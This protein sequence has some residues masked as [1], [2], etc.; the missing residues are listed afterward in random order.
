[1]ALSAPLKSVP[2]KRTIFAHNLVH[3]AFKPIGQ[4]PLKTENITVTAF[5]SFQYDK[6]LPYCDVVLE[7]LKQCN[8]TSDTIESL[9][10]FVTESK[11]TL[12]EDQQDLD[13]FLLDNEDYSQHRND[14]IAKIKFIEESHSYGMKPENIV[15][16][17]IKAPQNDND[18]EDVKAYVRD[19]LQQN[20]RTL[21]I[22]ELLKSKWDVAMS[23]ANS[24]ED[25][26][27]FVSSQLQINL[28]LGIQKLLKSKLDVARSGTNF[29]K[30]MVDPL[31]NKQPRHLWTIV[32]F[33][34]RYA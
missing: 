3:T 22:Q 19:Q 29:L 26:K 9:K 14:E 17:E 32:Q 28:T 13:F 30:T 33:R 1:M 23:N 31:K 2:G 12:K 20:H 5:F 6:L 21:D 18:Q 24:Q 4:T 34:W 25:F 10:T 15:T 11:Q 8:C 7:E 16:V 27:A